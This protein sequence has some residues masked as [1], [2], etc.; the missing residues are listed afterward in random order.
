MAL[1]G[2]LQTG[3]LGTGIDVD[4]DVD[5]AVSINCGFLQREFIVLLQ[6][7]FGIGAV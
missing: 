2:L 6:R 5:I 3:H 4:M 1:K 7:G